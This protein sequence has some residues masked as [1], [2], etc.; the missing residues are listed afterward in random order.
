[1]NTPKR[2]IRVPDYQ[3]EL[4]AAKA[5]REGM[6]ISHAIRGLLAAYVSEGAPEVRSLAKAPQ[7]LTSVLDDW[8]AA[9]DKAAG[10]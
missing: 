3:W 2:S 10:S 5:E 4:A 6:S 8:V 7:S 9:V 1:M